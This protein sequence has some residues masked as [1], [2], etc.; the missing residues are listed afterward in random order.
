MHTCTQSTTCK[1]SKQAAHRESAR[2][3][4]AQWRL[5]HMRAEVTRGAQPCA[6]AAWHRRWRKED[7]GGPINFVVHHPLHSPTPAAALLPLTTAQLLRSCRPARWLLLLTM[8]ILALMPMQGSTMEQGRVGDAAGR[9]WQHTSIPSTLAVAQTYI[10]PPRRSHAQTRTTHAGGA[11]Y[12]PRGST[13]LTHKC[14]ACAHTHPQ[15][16]IRA[17]T[18]AHTSAC[19]HACEHDSGVPLLRGMRASWWADNTT[20]ATVQ[21]P[22]APCEPP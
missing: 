9:S 20:Q 13:W 5:S 1:V 10:R 18:C 7:D 19:T 6:W 14:I 2:P 8:M 15:C 3:A 22:A 16:G 11:C 12:T 21:A 4:G 17:C